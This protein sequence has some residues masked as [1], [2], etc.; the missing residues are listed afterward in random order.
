M[1]SLFFA[2]AAWVGEGLE[3]TVR[4][5]EDTA[6]GG[7]SE[8]RIQELEEMMTQGESCI[9]QLVAEV[10]RLQFRCKGMLYQALVQDKQRTDVEF[11]L[12]NGE[13]AASAHRGMLSAVSPH[14]RTFFE[15]AM[16]RD[17][18]QDKIHVPRGICA[19]SVQ[20]LVEYVYTGESCEWLFCG[21]MWT[22]SWV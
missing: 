8:A 3:W 19:E 2:A 10:A 9:K 18:K 11:V 6:T 12:S 1:L 13:T 5:H 7:D 22:V 16:D 14:F 17:A 20:G 4:K 15:T 21:E